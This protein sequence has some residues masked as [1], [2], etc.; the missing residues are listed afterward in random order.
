MIDAWLPWAPLGL[1]LYPGQWDHAVAAP[2][3]RA[4]A[5]DIDDPAVRPYTRCTHARREVRSDQGK[6]FVYDAPGCSHRWF[7]VHDRAMTLADATA[8]ADGACW[9]PGP[10][11]LRCTQLRDHKGPHQSAD[12][13]RWPTTTRTIARAAGV[14]FEGDEP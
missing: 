14:V 4:L 5:D 9:H 13:S 1:A 12:G 2:P 11:G 6:L 3:P 8:I 7:V 10:R